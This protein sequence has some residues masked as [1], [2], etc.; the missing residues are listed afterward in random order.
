MK[1]L[2]FYL[3]LIPGIVLFVSCD[4]DEET[5]TSTGTQRYFALYFDVDRNSETNV[6]DIDV[7]F[8]TS[9]LSEV[10]TVTI[11]GV[12]ME[13]FGFEGGLWGSISN[14]QYSN[15]VNYSISLSGKTTSGSID[16][17][18]D[19]YNVLC[20]GIS[21]VEGQ[22]TI[23]IPQNNLFN[24]SWLCNSYDY[25]RIYWNSYNNYGNDNITVNNYTFYYNGLGYY[26]FSIYVHRGTM[27][28]SGSQPNVIGDYGKG[29]VFAQSDEFYFY[30]DYYTS[31][32]QKLPS[33]V[34]DDET[35]ITYYRDKFYELISIK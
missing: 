6:M 30:W 26:N 14:L 4:E 3:L 27:L 9:D 10:P 8:W 2:F 17:P 11:N 32:I 5:P 35:R 20:N 12:S 25:F 24:V 15:T 29:Y 1:K 23:P 13:N 21:V 16:L 22:N 34:E 33:N 28:T 19:P 7:S 18:S 31:S